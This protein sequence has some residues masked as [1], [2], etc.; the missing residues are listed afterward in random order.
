M[1]TQLRVLSEHAARLLRHAFAKDH[2][3]LHDDY[4][5]LDEI[6]SWLDIEIATFHPEDHPEGTYGFVDADE[7]ERLIWLCRDLPDQLRRFT[8]A[9]ELGHMILHFQD[10]RLLQELSAAHP[11]QAV[12]LALSIFPQPSSDDPCDKN[13]VQEQT[14]ELL[15]QEQF[16]K[17]LGIGQSYDP[18]SQREVAA[19]VFAAELLMPLERVRALYLNEQIPAHTL[20]TAFGVSQAA[21][22]NRLAGLLKPSLSDEPTQPTTVPA[23]PRPAR[24]YDE[25]QQ[26]AIEA[27]TPTLVVAGPGSGKTSTLIG[28]VIHLVDN[29]KVP[30]QHILALTFSRKAAREMEERLQQALDG[31]QP[32]VSTFHAFCADI[33]R[34]HGALVGLR[35]DFTL[36]DEAEGY[37]LLRQQANELRLKHYQKLHAP[38]YYFPDMLKA[39]SRAKDELVLPDQYMDLALQ[40]QRQSSDDTAREQAEKALE[41]ASVYALYQEALQRRG[42]TDFGGLLVLTIQLLRA[43]PEIL[44]QYQ[45]QYQHIV[46]DEF[47]DM[48]RASGVLLRELA[49]QARNVWVVGDANQAIYGFRGASPANISRFEADYPGATILPLSRNYRSHPDLVTIAESF[50]C[51]QLEPE[52]EP[53]KNQPACA[54]S[55]HIAITLASASDDTSELAGILQDIR[56][57][58]EQGYAYR[59]MV[60]LCRTRAQAQKISRALAGE[61]LP[62]IE[63]GGLL[64]QEHI[65]DVLSILLLLSDD[66]GMGLL[67]A[68]RQPEH[69]LAQRDLE[70][71]FITAHRQQIAPVT[72]VAREEI[73]LTISLQGK[74]ALEHLARLMLNLKHAPDTWSLLAQYLF[75][76]TNRIRSLLQH[77]GNDAHAASLLADYDG[78]LQIARRY[79][80]QL[81]TR[82]LQSTPDEE[83]RGEPEIDIEER[84][85]G[86]LEYLSLLVLLRQDSSSRQDS[87]EQEGEQADIIRVMT[88]H[89]SKGLEFPVVYMPGLSKRRFPLSAKSSPVNPPA[90]MVPP[91]SEGKAAHESGES[92][93]FYVGVTRA[94]EQLVLSYS[95][96]YGKQSYQRSPFLDA[97]EDALPEQR[98]TRLHWTP[99]VVGTLH[100]T[101]EEVPALPTTQPGARFASARQAGPLYATAIEAY[102]RCP[103]QYAYAHIYRFTPA[104]DGYQLFWQATQKTIEVLHKRCAEGK[105]D[106]VPTQQEI[107]E[108]YTKHWQELGGHN[109]HFAALYE[110]HGHEIVESIRRQVIAQ[111]DTQWNMRQGLDVN[112]EGKSVRVMVDRVESSTQGAPVKFVRARF[113]RSKDKPSADLRELFYTL[114]YRQHYGGQPEEIH[115][116]NMST[117]ETVPLKLTSRKEQS[118]Y[119]EIKRGIAGLERMDYPARPDDLFRCASCPFY[120]ICPA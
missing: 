77:A 18:R 45:Q 98:M 78:L 90:G 50:R 49:G 36:L 117:G 65:K 111:Q 54:P 14:T 109:S 8:L 12:P 112:V 92:C 97:L 87:E 88:V 2:P 103:R 85:R 15:D 31:I 106:R 81:R 68:A 118:L 95:E 41:I 38:A 66:S 107:Q 46:V 101:E 71:M 72:L 67:R 75:I 52:D 29:I 23:A 84:A 91:E 61:Q 60:V 25:F 13:D 10:G 70:H 116:H 44:A 34:K 102:L 42:D 28:R 113:G 3:G 100:D 89:A 114:A 64:D 9:H 86:F 40:M 24:S 63:R 105:G 120:F 21:M 16:E 43:Y 11:E 58:H 74:H 5:P 56:C 1:D 99:Q 55:S 6:V 22:L 53:G 32:K 73:P 4:S 48:N 35:P 93:L 69:Q 110:A 39:I 33:L 26:A 76:E 94:R 20:A 30:S 59:D 119:E 80:Q 7:D 47:Q 96:R 37:M 115:S 62:V 57:K 108:L 51:H 82:L 104:A 27:P 19:N 17:A 79:D 83:G